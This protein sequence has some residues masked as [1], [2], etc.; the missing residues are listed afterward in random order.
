[1][2]RR[3]V[4][5]VEGD[6]EVQAL[7]NLC[8][9]IRDYLQ[10]WDWFVDPQPVKQPRSRLVDERVPSPT[11]PCRADGTERAVRLALAR[12][13]DAVLLTCDSDDD[14]PAAWG[15]S[16]KAVVTKVAAGD[17]VMVVREYE[18]WLL[19]AFSAAELTK[20]GVKNPDRIRGAK[21]KLKRLVPKYK[22]TTHQLEI[23]R[24]ID[25]ERLRRASDSFDKLVRSLAAIF[26]VTAPDRAQ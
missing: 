26:G 20:V 9:R 14:C 19:H 8:S 6:G 24:K 23:T 1:M 3:L 12:P 7:P 16:A 17:A 4:C 18:A 15:P 21:E 5:V 25:L 2:A 11:R 13:A 22:P 10:A